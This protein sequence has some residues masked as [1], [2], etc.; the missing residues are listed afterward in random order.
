MIRKTKILWLALVAV[1]ALGALATT[2]VWAE[3]ELP[4]RF[5][6]PEHAP[7]IETGEKGTVTLTAEKETEGKVECTSHYEA[8]MAAI[9]VTEFTVTPTYSTCSAFGFAKADTNFE[10][11]HYEFTLEPGI[12]KS[13]GGGETH[14]KGPFHIICPEGKEIHITTTMFGFPFCTVTVPPQTPTTPTVDTK[15][16]GAGKTRTV[17]FTWT[18]KGVTYVV[19]NGGGACGVVGKHTGALDGA[20]E[21]LA[22]EDVGGKK[23]AQTGF[24]IAGN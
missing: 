3:E 22:Y 17:R 16:L 13:T 18:V 20:I 21:V 6:T 24:R 11:C 23:G 4:K 1:L 2:G 14:T 8:E 5:E 7:T 12:D 15:N 19:Q 9:W 10:G